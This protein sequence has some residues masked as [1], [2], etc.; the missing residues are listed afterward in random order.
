MVQKLLSTN[1]DDYPSSVA[2]STNGK[3]LAVGFAS[4][5]IEI[6]DPIEMKQV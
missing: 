4:S 1:E 6:W 2:W 5:R 3:M